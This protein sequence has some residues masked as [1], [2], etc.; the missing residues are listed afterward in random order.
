[1]WSAIVS[2]NKEGW[3]WKNGPT[4]MLSG[5]LGLYLS[6]MVI[7]AAGQCLDSHVTIRCRSRGWYWPSDA[8]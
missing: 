1:M 2:S 4:V 3:G 7:C 8:R 5:H 6:G